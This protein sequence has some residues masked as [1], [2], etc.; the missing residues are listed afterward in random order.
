MT[1]G[2]CLPAQLS[3]SVSCRRCPRAGWTATCSV[4][5]HLAGP[6]PCPSPRLCQALKLH[7]GTEPFS[8]P[9]PPSRPQRDRRVLLPPCD[10]PEWE[11]TRGGR[12]LVPCGKAAGRVAAS[13]QLA[14]CSDPT[15]PH[16]RGRTEAGSALESEKLQARGL[17]CLAARLD[18]RA[19]TRAGS[20]CR[21]ALGPRSP[22]CAPRMP[23]AT[24]SPVVCPLGG[25]R[26]SPGGVRS[27][28]GRVSA[29]AR[30]GPGSDPPAS[31][32]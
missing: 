19:E 7:T 5:L 25:C 20:R 29:G 21:D 13:R 26:S 18:P 15:A 28:G 30:A 2:H 24:H 22:A 11:A 17:L 12:H 31:R 9:G 1:W 10:R 32:P 6:A 16:T 4:G 23:T 8:L 27:A 3:G 14:R